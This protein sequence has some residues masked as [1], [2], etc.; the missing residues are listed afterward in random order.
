MKWWERLD[1]LA[2][3]VGARGGIETNELFIIEDLFSALG[4]ELGVDPYEGINRADI[5][6]EDPPEDWPNPYLKARKKT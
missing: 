5:D 4:N 2:E 6:R 1:Q 3:E